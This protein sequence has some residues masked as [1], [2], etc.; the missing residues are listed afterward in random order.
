MPLSFAA[1]AVSSGSSL[2]HQA[3][4]PDITVNRPGIYHASF[5]SSVSTEPGASIP[6]TLTINLA[7]DGNT[8]PG[9]SATH[10]FA[11][12]AEA[13]TI[14]FTVPFQV[15]TTPSTL[16]AVP[17]QSGFPFSNSLL[18]VVRLGDTPTT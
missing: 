17:V 16:R 6:A 18:T 7:L 3:G 8:L 14:S 4:T 9:A 2:S 12:S 15:T 10:T 1:T 5:H 11:S 13:S